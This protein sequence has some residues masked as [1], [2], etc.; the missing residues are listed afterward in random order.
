MM[1]NAEIIKGID[2]AIE[3]LTTIKNALAVADGAVASKY[4]EEFKKITQFA[5][6][7]NISLEVFEDI[8]DFIYES[9]K[10]VALF[11]SSTFSIFSKSSK[12]V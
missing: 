11:Q 6:A 9:K 3:G 12:P 2:L 1:N 5:Y 7:E 4:A 8:D 10:G